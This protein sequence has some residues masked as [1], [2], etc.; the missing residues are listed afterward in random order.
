MD[1]PRTE[2]RTQRMSNTRAIR[3]FHWIPALMLLVAC[4]APQQ[5]ET[6]GT[7][8]QPAEG[9]DRTVLPIHE[10]KRQTYTEL[11]VREHRSHLHVGR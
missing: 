7:V 6:A 5:N 1:F 3:P 11:D 9:L 8:E 4:G 2:Q 10:P